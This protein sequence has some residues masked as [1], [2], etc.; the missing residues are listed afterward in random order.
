MC[1]SEFSKV[2]VERPKARLI[3]QNGLEF[4]GYAFGATASIG[5]EVGKLKIYYIQ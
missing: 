1:V 5:G 3:L 4:Q 2:P